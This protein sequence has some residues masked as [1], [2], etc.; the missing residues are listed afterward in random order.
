[1]VGAAPLSSPG[2]PAARVKT[3]LQSE[4]AVTPGAR[5]GNKNIPGSKATVISYTRWKKT[6]SLP[7]LTALS[8]SLFPRLRMRFIVHRHQIRE[9]NLRVFLRGGQPRVAQQLLTRPQIRAIGE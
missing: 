1:M 9:R 6:I 8:L 4:K 2:R 5:A 3:D 7:V